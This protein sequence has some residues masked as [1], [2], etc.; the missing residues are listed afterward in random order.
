MSAPAASQTAVDFFSLGNVTVTDTAVRVQGRTYP[1]SGVAGVDI[2][3]PHRIAYVVGAALA[4]GG[5]ALTLNAGSPPGAFALLVAAAV[6]LLATLNRPYALILRTTRG[7]QQSLT[8]NNRKFV[9]T[10]KQ[11]IE[12]ALSKHA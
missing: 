10:V 5:A 12:E 7:S 2:Q 11:A 8:H 1:L 4:V 9:Q 3:A 6:C